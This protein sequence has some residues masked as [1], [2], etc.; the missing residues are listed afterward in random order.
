MIPSASLVRVAIGLAR[1]APA[2]VLRALEWGAGSL[3]YAGQHDRRR[4]LL[5]NLSRTAPNVT[6]WPKV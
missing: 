2:P 1:V 5:D 4:I 3:A 6:S